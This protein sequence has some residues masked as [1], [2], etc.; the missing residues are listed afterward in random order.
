MLASK[1]V[2]RSRRE[3]EGRLV[4]TGDAP[5]SGSKAM[6]AL[7][8]YRQAER[9]KRQAER[10]AVREVER[11]AWEDVQGIEEVSTTVQIFHE[12]PRPLLAVLGEDGKFHPYL[13]DEESELA[14]IRA[15]LL[16]AHDYGGRETWLVKGRFGGQSVKMIYQ[17]PL[18][19]LK[20]LWPD[21]ARRKRMEQAG[22][23]D[24]AE[25]VGVPVLIER[26]PRNLSG[27]NKR[28]CDAGSSHS[29]EAPV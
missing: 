2:A 21:L 27:R 17:G 5:K 7:Q 29:V 4:V 24:L 20:T 18:S 15:Q 12:R 22:A 28:R 23:K 8:A 16:K 13:T 11:I 3:L 25:T 14:A 10:D 9:E 1:H 26:L 19:A 6:A